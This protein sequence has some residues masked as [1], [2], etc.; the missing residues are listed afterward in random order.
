[1]AQSG[2]AERLL[3]L[4]PW[5]IPPALFGFATRA[6][7]AAASIRFAPDRTGDPSMVL[8][9][10]QAAT[11]GAPVAVLGLLVGK[12]VCRTTWTA[13]ALRSV[14]VLASAVGYF[15]GCEVG[16]SRANAVTREAFRQF[17]ARSEPT[18]AAVEGFVRLHSRPPTNWAELVPQFLPAEPATGFA[19]QPQFELLVGE[20]LRRRGSN[21][22][23]L[24]VR[25]G[26]TG[27]K[28]DECLFLPH[29]DYHRTGHQ[30]VEPV[31]RW[32]LVHW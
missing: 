12:F 28:W 14:L 23:G 25:A 3:Q 5:L 20:K 13:F 22:W 31:G 26:G 4:L 7:P 11:F 1:M 30:F 19:L 29:Q 21:S 17:A 2:I 6:W 10:G 27:L 18:L 9:L 24:R 15:T 32:A 8:L 16:T